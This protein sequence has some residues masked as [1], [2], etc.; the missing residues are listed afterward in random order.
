MKKWWVKLLVAFAVMLLALGLC[1]LKS[2]SDSRARL[3]QYQRRLVAAGENLD[4]EAY[5]PP[6]VEAE[7]NGAD[8]IEDASRYFVPNGMSMVTSNPPTAMCLVAPGKAKS[9]WAENE[10]IFL[11]G[12]YFKTNSWNALEADLTVQNSAFELLQQAAARP[13]FDFGTDYRNP[14]GPLPELN[15]ISQATAL[16]SAKVIF[17]LHRGDTASAGTNFQ[18]LLAIA[19]TVQNEPL[20]GSQQN[21]MLWMQSV[22]GVQW[23]LLQATNITDAQLAAFQ[24]GW[25]NVDFVKPMETTERMTRSQIFALMND[26][27]AKGPVGGSVGLGPSM[28][29]PFDIGDLI[30]SLR[31]RVGYALWCESWSYDDELVVLKVYQVMAETMEQAE[32]NSYF[33]DAFAERDRKIAAL[34]L[35]HTNWLRKRLGEEYEE[36]GASF[37]RMISFSVDR[38]PVAEAWRQCAIAAIALKRYQL[39]HGSLPKDLSALVPEFVPVLPHDPIDGKPLRY[40]LNPDG[41]FLLYSVGADGVDDG[42]NAKPIPPATDWRWPDARD[43]VWPQPATSLEIQKYYLHPPK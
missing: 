4:I 21:R 42:G 19:N 8:L 20:N 26:V 31:R 9:A 3:E 30:R 12:N 18:T 35:N 10:V 23:E 39:H 11:K 2:G 16:L 13:E 1:F 15:K 28:S 17:D 6:H 14:N 24:S 22:V 34:S 25:T 27:R 5:T 29:S 37:A 38:V 41:T 40:R 7:R 32:T 33:K 36:A 43:W